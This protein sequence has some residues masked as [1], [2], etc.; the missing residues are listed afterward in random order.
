MDTPN[1]PLSSTSSEESHSAWATFT[2]PV[3]QSKAFTMLW[4]GH[5]IAMLGSSVTT[6]ILPLVIYSL[7]GS[8]TIMGLAMTV[9]MLPNVLILPF[10][11]MIVDRID[12]IRLLL[13]TNIARFG[14]MSVAAVLMFTGGMK[15]PFLFIGLALYGLMD[16]I[17]NPAYSALRAQVF[18]PD[19]RNAANA[20]SQISIQAVRLLGPPLGGFIVSFS[21]PGVGFGLDS[22]TYLISFACFWMLSAH[23]TSIIGKRQAADPEQQDQGGQ[24]F[25]KDFIAGFTIL[26]SHPWLWITILAFSFINICYSGIIAVL[27]PWL[28]KVHHSYSPVVYGVAMASSGV[29]AMVG[30]FVYGSRKH[31]KHRGLLAYLGALVSGLALLLLSVVTWMPGLI[32]SMMLE[33]F[34]IMIFAIIWETSLQELVPAQSFGRVASLDLMFSFALLPVGYLA[35]GAVADKLGGIFTIGLF[36]AIG[37]CIVLGVLFVPHI[38]RF[39]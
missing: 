19:I 34:G 29:G 1:S 17:F 22:V 30:A 38:R 37:M 33:G 36:A 12:R 6:V 4:L 31:W 3:K 28:F 7:T 18:T 16:G 21:S 32:M 35:V 15:M 5:W 11:G 9:Y 14:L 20:L 39:Q 26:K 13:F 25:V 8:T 2:S 24:H 10:A 27:V 23:L